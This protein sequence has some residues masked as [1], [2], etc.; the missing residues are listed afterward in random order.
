M[1]K[2]SVLCL[3][4]A[5]FFGAQAQFGNLG[6]AVRR[7][8]EKK[9]EQKVKK[10]VEKEVDKALDNAFGLNQQEAATPQNS[11]KIATDEN[12]GEPKEGAE[13][14]IPTPE[15]V[16]AT[17]PALPTYQNIAEYLCEQNRENPRTL[18]ML[19]NPTMQFITQMGVAAA[20]GYVAMMSQ[21]GS[22]NIYYYDKQLLEELG[23]NEDEY[24]KMSEK[25]QQELASKYAVEL[26]ERYIRTAEMLGNDTEYQKMLEKY[27]AVEKEIEDLYTKAEE[28]CENIWQ[29][30]YSLKKQPTEN[31]MCSY[32]GEAVPVYYKA[33]T[34]AMKLRKSRQL[35]IAKKIDLYVQELANKRRG[36]VYAGFYNQGGL[37][38]TSYVGDAARLMSIPD[39]R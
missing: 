8:V 37:C 7:G 39:P 6:N 9:V 26:Q 38:A 2:L 20:S 18:K 21:P 19:T 34:E 33:I 22:G 36:E 1:K 23:I 32:Y 10:K 4:L 5:L 28:T 25:E 17:V 35:D 30:N 31:D 11:N 27:N 24:E 29:K 12:T 3:A 13:G 16:M 14:K 15:E